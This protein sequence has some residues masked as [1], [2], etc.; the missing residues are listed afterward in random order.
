MAV[1]LW[2][3]TLALAALLIVD[4]GEWAEPGFSVYTLF[5]HPSTMVGK[6]LG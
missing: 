2:V 3:V 6:A 5:V 4:R 1:R